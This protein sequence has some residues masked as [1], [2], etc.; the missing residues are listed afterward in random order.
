MFDEWVQSIKTMSIFLICAQT[1][2][3]FKPKGAYEKY[4]KLLVSI[5]LLVQLLEPIGNML[6][7]LRKGELQSKILN[8]ERRLEWI[9]QQN[10]NIDEQADNIWNVFLRKVQEETLEQQVEENEE[11]LKDKE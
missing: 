1:L 9:Q 3:H 7:I 6:G 11:N 2:I 5:M 10:Y 4:I 8:A